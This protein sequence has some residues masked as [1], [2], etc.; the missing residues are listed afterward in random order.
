M[1]INLP[2]SLFP[3]SVRKREGNLW[4]WIKILIMYE[5]RTTQLP[6]HQSL[7][8]EGYHYSYYCSS[9]YWKVTIIVFSGSPRSTLK[10]TALYL[11]GFLH[12]QLAPAMSISLGP[13]LESRASCPHF[14]KVREHSNWYS[15]WDKILGTNISSISRFLKFHMWFKKQ[16]SPL[17]ASLS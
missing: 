13:H 15:L 8:N 12:A 6:E 7:I 4:T 9:S 2:K 10:E 5:K 16:I 3:Y 1:P 11:K 14:R 17:I